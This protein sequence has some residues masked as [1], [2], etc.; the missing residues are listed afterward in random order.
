MNTLFSYLVFGLAFNSSVLLSDAE[1]IGVDAKQFTYPAN[2]EPDKV[3]LQIVFVNFDVESQKNMNMSDTE[4]VSY[5][6]STFLGTSKAAESTKERQI[7]DIKSAGEILKT[8]IPVASNIEIH[9]I[10][11]Q[12]NTKI[13]IAFKSVSTIN[14]EILENVISEITSSLKLE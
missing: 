6:K 12:N 13:A 1:D 4:L 8:K 3:E 11:L 9:I 7:M 10:T 14:S 5:V 2:V